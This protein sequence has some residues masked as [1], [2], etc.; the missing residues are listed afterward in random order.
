M[1]TGLAPYL[2][3]LVGGIWVTLEVFAIGTVVWMAAA[4][5]LGFARMSRRRTVRFASGCVV[6]VFRGSSALVQLFWAFYVLPLV[7]I[8]LSPLA[9][10]VIVLGLN[11]GSYASEVVRGA[12]KGVAKAQTDAATVL[13]LSP[14]KRQ[15]FVVLPQAVATMVPPFGNSA[16]DFLQ[17]TAFVSLVTVLDVTAR[18]QLVE[19]SDA[20]DITL[21]YTLL[22]LVYFTG[23]LILSGLTRL[24][25]KLIRKRWGYTPPRS[26]GP[27]RGFFLPGFL[28]RGVSSYR[29]RGAR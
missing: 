22:L 8:Y 11:E 24:A 6:E 1:A 17:L 15:R 14:W 7:G 3:Y 28:R 27:A 18:A 20:R 5:A 10:A 12:V 19:Q 4:F 26:K 21:I 25:E 23:T 16:I 29:T 2:P 13:G 9:A